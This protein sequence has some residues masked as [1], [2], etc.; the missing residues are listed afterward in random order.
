[1]DNPEDN[2]LSDFIREQVATTPSHGDV[3]HDLLAFLARDMIEMN[4]EKQ[5]E[6]KGFL[7][8]LER[9]IGTKVENLTH[10]TAIRS[11]HERPFPALLAALRTNRRR[12]GPGIDVSSRHFQEELERE[13]T[14]SVQKVAPLKAKVETTDSLI[15]KIVYRLYGLT[16]DEI[17]VVKHESNSASAIE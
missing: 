6:I 8:W 12:L 15:D 9:Q 1:M 11:Y 17:N 13:F 7:T 16:D 14:V 10:K 4:K 2:R 3:I 5:S